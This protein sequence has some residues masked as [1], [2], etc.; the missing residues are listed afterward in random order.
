M[1]AL[2]DVADSPKIFKFFCWTFETQRRKE[3]RQFGRRGEET[4]F[5]TANSLK[6]ILPW[7]GGSL[8]YLSL[9]CVRTNKQLVSDWRWK[10]SVG[11]MFEGREGRRDIITLLGKQVSVT[12]SK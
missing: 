6:K 1:T 5:P 12:K 9:L 11:I 4:D 10:I 3:E 7:L 2:S 8:F